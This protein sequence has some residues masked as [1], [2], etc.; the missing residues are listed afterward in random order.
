M[1]EKSTVESSS[2]SI[3]ASFETASLASEQHFGYHQRK[4]ERKTGYHTT[5]WYLQA[6]Y[7]IF[8]LQRYSYTERKKSR[9]NVKKDLLRYKM[10][11]HCKLLN[12]KGINSVHLGVTW[13][14][15]I[16]LLK[17]LLRSITIC[18]IPSTADFPDIL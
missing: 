14:A 7:I 11:V 16:L 17:E 9:I 4:L 13:I 2:I 12:A 8:E 1:N 15:Y 5:P 10:L 3:L 6:V 18:W